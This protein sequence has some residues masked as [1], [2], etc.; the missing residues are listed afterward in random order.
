VRFFA[1][2][3]PGQRAGYRQDT[4]NRIFSFAWIHFL[5]FDELTGNRADGSPD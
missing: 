5:E 1:R 4:R 2:R 3:A